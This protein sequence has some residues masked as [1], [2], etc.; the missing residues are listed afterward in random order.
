MSATLEAV[1]NLV[2]NLVFDIS[3][4][5]VLVALPPKGSRFKGYEQGEGKA[6]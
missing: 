2:G 1:S 4:F 6:L 5:V 3:E